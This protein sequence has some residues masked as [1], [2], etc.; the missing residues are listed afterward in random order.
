MHAVATVN[1]FD[2]N[3]DITSNLYMIKIMMKEYVNNK[4]EYDKYDQYDKIM[5]RIV[6]Y[7]RLTWKVA[8]KQFHL[9]LCERCSGTSSCSPKSDDDEGGGVDDNDED[10]G[11]DDDDEDGDVKEDDNGPWYCSLL[12]RAGQTC[13]PGPAC[14]Q[15]YSLYKY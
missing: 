8:G 2:I 6:T 10:D 12:P 4:K 14:Q 5:K 11:V 9:L 1:N 7:W 15:L 13:E 3:D